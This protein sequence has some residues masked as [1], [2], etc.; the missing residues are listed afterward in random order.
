MSLIQL[1][2]PTPS[3]PGFSTI[4]L[5]VGFRP[6]FALGSLI[7]ALLMLSWVFV[8]R[9]T[10]E[11]PLANIFS[12]HAHEMI[13]AYAIAIVAGFLLT[14]VRNWAGLDTA[15]GPL[16]LGLVTLWLLPRPLS[17]MLA[18]SLWL[19]I[20]DL[21]FIPA[22]AICLAVPIIRSKNWRNLLFIPILSAF[23]ICNLLYHLAIHQQI[24]I[25]PS[26]PIL[27]ALELVLMLITII[28]ARVMPMF[29]RNGTQ[30]AVEPRSFPNQPL[31]LLAVGISQLLI[32]TLL[33]IK[34]IQAASSL[35]FAAVIIWAWLGW[36]G[37]ALWRKPMLWVLHIA[38]LGL[39]ISYI[40]KAASQYHLIANS[41]WI[42]SAAV[43]C[44]GMMTIGFIG[45]VSLGHSGRK[46]ECSRLMLSSYCLMLL[47]VV[48]RL[49]ASIWPNPAL[50]D[51]A[52]FCWSL[53][54]LCFAIEFI[55]YLS[56]PRADGKAL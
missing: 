7:G 5:S 30:A 46:L 20:I 50:W 41:F 53:A 13:F 26:T 27:F 42:H 19:S 35:I 40:S 49:A 11:L 55:P 52:A 9:G 28:G 3:N 34:L 2:E 25:N 37:T 33:D 22:L 32:N 54:L 47:A 29:T 1:Q 48:L 14:A 15:R 4:L 8:Y 18:P 6:F 16:L 56:S 24:E 44:I 12:W 21:T 10:F 43:L 23:F 31:I 17:M 36:Q 39:A 38:Y 51:G 45:R